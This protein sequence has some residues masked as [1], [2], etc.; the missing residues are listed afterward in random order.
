ME[1]NSEKGEKEY[2]HDNK[3]HK[4]VNPLLGI[5]VIVGIVRFLTRFLFVFMFRSR[6]R[7]GYAICTLLQNM[8]FGQAKHLSQHPKSNGLTQAY[9]NNIAMEDL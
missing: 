9:L 2:I 6:S 1:S 7:L 4:A 3:V 5:I 8:Y